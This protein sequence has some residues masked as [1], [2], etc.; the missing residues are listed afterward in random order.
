MPIILSISAT[1]LDD[2]SLQELTRR[3]R[4]D[5]RDEVGVEADQGLREFTLRPAE[6]I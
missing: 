1:D 6:T 5:L 2:E 4:Q 3:L